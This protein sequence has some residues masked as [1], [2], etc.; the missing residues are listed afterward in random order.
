MRPLLVYG[1]AVLG[2][3]AA[4]LLRLAVDPL[5]GSQAVPF[6]TY[7]LAV[8]FVAAGYGFRAATLTILLSALASAYYFLAPEGSLLVYAS[9]DVA[10]LCLFVAVSF[11]IAFLGSSRRR[12]L[13]RAGREVELRQE[14]ERLEREQGKRFETTL[15]SIGDAVISTDAA[16]RVTFANQVA[17]SLLRWPEAEMMGKPLDDVFQI[18]N[19]YSREKVESPVAKV[20]REGAVVGLANH[21]ILIARDG[22]EI[23]IDDSGAPIRGENGAIQGIVLVF[24]DVTT[25]RRADEESRLLASIVESSDDAIISKN[26]SG[27]I[28][29]WNGGGATNIRI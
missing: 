26:L 22:T 3:V 9:T 12:A 21:T 7:F 13:E 27:V 18:I 23:P 16:G 1:I 17:Q 24:R 28:T 10:A 2:A 19:E 15:A 8:I 6:I 20:L 25:R 29:S 14:A 11:A 5:V 4:T